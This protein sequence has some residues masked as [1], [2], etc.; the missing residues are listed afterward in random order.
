M[1][2]L[3]VAIPVFLVLAALE[4][5]AASRRMGARHKLGD[6]VS[7]VGCGALDQIVNL[8]VGAGFLTLYAFLNRHV[9]VLDLPPR[10][11]I[12]WIAAVLL[13]DLA[14]YVFHR[15]SHRVNVLWAAH[16]VHHQSEDYTFAVSLRQ[17]AIA[18]WVSYL[19][20]LPLA[21]LDIPVEMFVIVHGVYQVYQFFV[22]TRFIPALGPLEHVL[23]TPVLH[24]VHH[25]RDAEFLDKNYGGFFI[26]WDKLFGSFAPYTR[27]PNYGVTAGISSWSPFWANLHPYAELARR[28]RR[29]PDR[30]AA[31]EVWL[32]PP[33]WR[34]TWD[35]TDVRTPG[36][37]APVPR[38]VAVYSLIQLV[39]AAAAA[40]ALLWPGLVAT[41]V[42]RFALAAF[43]LSSLVTVAAFWDRR[44]WARRAEAFRL[45]MIGG[46]AAA[47]VLAGGITTDIAAM[48]A[49][50]CALSGGA[51]PGA[52]AAVETEPR[53]RT[54][55]PGAR[56]ALN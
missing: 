12:T 55:P 41:G 47:L 32:R 27:E 56:A 45:G 11:P 33:E 9:T 42:V 7:G 51:L 25:G 44:T 22:H 46:G 50:A 38:A 17:G 13:H 18:T 37:G 14:Y 16:A 8:A 15:A 35:A 6:L 36:Y 43:V 49:A 3:V 34:G 54:P 19:F 48:I 20:Y 39:V 21:I 1:N 30:R 53:L 4:A 28:A 10:S 31:L 52:K 29:A 26:V 40:L 24:R 2:P 23:A 5:V